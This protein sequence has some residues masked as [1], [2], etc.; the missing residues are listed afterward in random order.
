VTWW[1]LLGVLVA[2][3]AG[4]GVVAGCWNRRSPLPGLAWLALAG[5]LGPCVT[6]AALFAAGSIGLPARTSIPIIAAASIAACLAGAWRRWRALP[7]ATGAPL[8]VLV[9]VAVSIG[10]ST[11]LASRTHLGWDG[12]VVWYHKARIVAASDGRM[13][14]ATLADP[15]RIWMAPD[16]PLHVP[17][18][19]AWVRLWQPVEDERAIKV[20][21]AAW[22]AA[23]LMLVAAAVLERSGSA[24]RAACALVMV[25]AAPRLLIGEGSYTS[26][27]ADGPLAGLVAALV[28]LVWR[29][30]D[31]ST[32]GWWPLAAIVA[33]AVVWT[34]QEGVIAAIAAG[35]TCAWQRRS[36]RPLA[37]AAPALIVAGAWQA[38][39][40]TRGA[41]TGMAYAWPGIE[42][43][44]ARWPVVF[45]VYAETWADLQTW[46]VLWPSLAALIAAQRRQLPA[47]VA[48]VAATACAGA[49]AFLTSGWPDV[50]SHLLVTVPRLHVALAAS[51]VLI[52]LGM[53]DRDAA[54]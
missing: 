17:L 54:G 26:G 30:Q 31:D 48:I 39:A 43:A 20:L 49:L 5:L 33:V 22:C 14:L 8:A 13:P 27:Y 19:M 40:A 45:G 47:A 28:W 21:P 3:A 53:R 52:A 50:R 7:R 15:T 6:G 38:W 42:L 1:A 11:W 12:T 34:K 18:A 44:L 16:Y 41:V 23:L 35:A 36:V 32:R 51:L 29:D 2:W 24:T 4:A 10:W 46:G 25:A 9:L 37:V